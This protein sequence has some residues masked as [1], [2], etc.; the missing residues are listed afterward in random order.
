VHERAALLSDH[1]ALVVPMRD[2][3]AA[4]LIPIMPPPR[5]AIH[6]FFDPAVTGDPHPA[7]VHPTHA[8]MP[9]ACAPRARG[10]QQGVHRQRVGRRLTASTPTACRQSR[11]AR[12]NASRTPVRP[13]GS[14]GSCG[15]RTPLR[16][17]WSAEASN[18]LDPLALDDI[19]FVARPPMTKSSSRPRVSS[20]ISAARPGNAPGGVRAPDAPRAGPRSSGRSGSHPS[21]EVTK[22][23][24]KPYTLGCFTSS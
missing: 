17:T 14:R 2:P 18:E 20:S 4:R 9:G 3:P 1:D 8:L 15:A 23:V 24:S 16:N 11:R 6:C 13:T 21:R 22:P 19:H 10:R 5:G 12:R 7:A